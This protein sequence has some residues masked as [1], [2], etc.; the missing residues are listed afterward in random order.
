MKGGELGFRSGA[1]TMAAN[2]WWGRRL[3]ACRRWQ[4]YVLHTLRRKSLNTC[5]SGCF[6]WSHLPVAEFQLSSLD[7]SSAYFLTYNILIIYSFLA[8][9]YLAFVCNSGWFKRILLLILFPFCCR[10]WNRIHQVERL[11]QLGIPFERFSVLVRRN[12]RVLIHLE[13]SSSSTS[14]IVRE[15]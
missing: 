15:E 13:D 6:Q 3:P 2:L 5:L 7:P 8:S 11:H 4:S 14:K 12:I 10:F 1:S 9:V